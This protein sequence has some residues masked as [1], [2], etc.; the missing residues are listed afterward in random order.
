[1]DNDQSPPFLK[2]FD[3]VFVDLLTWINWNQ[4]S[5]TFSN[6]VS[7]LFDFRNQWSP[8]KIGTESHA[9]HP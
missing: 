4:R 7:L 6:I 5:I 9:L 8:S 1:M 3:L 2:Y